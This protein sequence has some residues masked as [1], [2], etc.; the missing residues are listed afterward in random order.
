MTIAF[1][2]F[3]PKNTQITHSWFQIYAG[4]FF[5]FCQI[6]QVDK[7]EGVDFKY[8]NTVFE[9]QLQNLCV[10]SGVSGPKFRHFGFSSNFTNRQIWGCWLQIWQDCF[11]IPVQNIQNRHFWS[12]I[13]AFLFLREVSWSPEIPK[14]GVFGP[15]FRYSSFLEKF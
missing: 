8:R 6:F 7:F 15:K 12:Q 13:W 11:Q 2:K 10:F 14:S 5:F 1:F 3:L 9:F 4:F